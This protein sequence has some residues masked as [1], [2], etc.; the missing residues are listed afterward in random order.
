ML[1]FRVVSMVTLINYQGTPCTFS[2]LT[3]NRR[4]HCT[5]CESNFSFLLELSKALNGKWN[6]GRRPSRGGVGLKGRYVK[7]NF[8]LSPSLARSI[9]LTNS[10]PSEI[11]YQPKYSYY[12]TRI[13]NRNKRIGDRGC[14]DEL[15]ISRAAWKITAG[16]HRHY[17]VF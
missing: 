3:Y 10:G 5:L 9:N 7:P 17:H 11:I 13:N 1:P 2:E 12:Y 16:H 15:G 4:H 8:S 14:S 6:A